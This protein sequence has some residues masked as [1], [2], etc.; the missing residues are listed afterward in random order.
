MATTGEDVQIKFGASIEGLTAGVNQVKEAI[1]G[2]SAPINS[3]MA[4]LG[5][6]GEAVLAAFATERVTDWAK[7]IGQV[8]LRTTNLAQSVGLSAEEMQGFGTLLEGIGGSA[9]SATRGLIM[10]EAHLSQGLSNAVSPAG[11][12][13]T[14]LGITHRQLDE[15]MHSTGDLLELMRSKFSQ[16]Q[17][18]PN[19]TALGHAL[20]GRSMQ[21]LFPIINMTREQ[22][23]EYEAR[24]KETG[25]DMSGPMVAAAAET[26]KNFNFLGLAV[27]GISKT[28]FGAFEPAIDLARLRR[29]DPASHN[30]RSASD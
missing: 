15:A 28:L 18:G 11:K 2:L 23:E 3:F 30:F 8:A 25:A 16:Y 7:E 13:L 6:I 20:L 12:A 22:F 24:I 26:G 1:E 27:E 4:S 5:G 10:L 14:A 9:E 29:F 17:D 19:K 21:E